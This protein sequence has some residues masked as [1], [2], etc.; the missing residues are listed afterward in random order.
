MTRTKADAAQRR[1]VSAC[2]EG[3]AD[4]P[5][6][7]GGFFFFFLFSRV[8]PITLAFH[9]RR[10]GRWVS[11]PASM[12]PAF[13]LNR[14]RAGRHSARQGLRGWDC[15]SGAGAG[16]PV[17]L[18]TFFARVRFSACGRRRPLGCRSGIRIRGR[19]RVGPI[20]CNHRALPSTGNGGDVE[21]HGSAGSPR[22]L[23]NGTGAMLFVG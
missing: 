20:P 6:A 7:R 4:M 14:G 2:A 8:E 22:R 11:L 9:S 1:S 19:R 21:R 18:D 13:A 16:R 10:I 15:R 3:S 5:A 17:W 23:V 12:A